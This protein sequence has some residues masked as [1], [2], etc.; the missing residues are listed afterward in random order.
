MLKVWFTVQLFPGIRKV[1]TNRTVRSCMNQMS[2]LKIRRPQTDKNCK[3][4]ASK[5]K[6]SE[7]QSKH[8]WYESNNKPNIM[9][10]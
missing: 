2:R 6:L 9:Y 8:G 5:K 10:K 3:D 4:K 1:W 7:T